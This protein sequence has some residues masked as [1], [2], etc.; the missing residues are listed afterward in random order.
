MNEN[1]LKIEDLEVKI[2]EKKVLSG[3]NLSVKSGEIHAI[4]GP[5]GCGKSSLCYSLLGHPKYEVGK[6]KVML[7]NQD[8]L[9][10]P[11]EQRAREGIFLAFQY[12]KEVDGITFGNFLRQA[13]NTQ[14]KAANTMSKEFSPGEYFKIMEENLNNLNM[15]RR[16]IGRG[17]NSGFSGGEKKKA[18]IVQMMALNPKFAFLD[19][20]DSGLDIDALKDV[21]TG[22]KKCFEETGMGLVLITHTQRLLHQINADHVHVMVDGKIVKSG[23]MELVE[24][25]EKKGYKEYQL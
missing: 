2:E 4:M 12:P 20:I 24:E 7:N 23:G 19:E 13:V 18:E 16:F 6:G 21:T 15:D 1:V 25:L 3:F 17:V 14:R 8:I 11:T 9:K 22:I 10:M 5:N